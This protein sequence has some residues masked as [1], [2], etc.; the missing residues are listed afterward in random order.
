MSR[1]PETK[2]NI[3]KTSPKLKLKLKSDLHIAILCT[4]QRG[5]PT[6]ILKYLID[7]YAD[8]A[9]EYNNDGWMFTVTKAI[10]LLSIKESAEG[11]NK[12]ITTR[13]EPKRL[14][15]S[16]SATHEIVE[17]CLH[18]IVTTKDEEKASQWFRKPIG[19]TKDEGKAFQE[20][21]EGGN[22]VITTRLEPKRLKESIS[23]THEIVEKCLHGIVTT[24][25]EEKASQWFRKP[26]GTTKDEGK[27]F[28]WY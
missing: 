19:T 18:G 12:V 10:A 20:S 22:K 9:K 11:G 13:L 24:K 14:K 4:Q 26:I 6:A 17:K 1:S 5:N 7:Y 8:N 27:A 23:A 21:A 16:I 2:I 3:I 28:Q 25:D 15:E